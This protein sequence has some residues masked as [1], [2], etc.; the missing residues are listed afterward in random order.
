MEFLFIALLIILDQASK[1][2]VKLNLKPIDNLDLIN[3]YFSLTYVEN[4]GA[5]LGI[6]SNKKLL[7]I[8]I[9]SIVIFAMIIYLIKG[10]NLTKILRVSFILIIAGAIG[11]LIDRIYLSYVIDFIHFYVRS[12]DLPVFNIADICVVSGTIILAFHLLMSHD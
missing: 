3:G 10:Q 12:Y 9:T 8:G 2:I 1:I 6:F 7:L 4:R 11:N 5:A